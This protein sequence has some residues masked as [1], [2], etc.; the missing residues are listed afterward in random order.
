MS[1]GGIDEYLSG[2][3]V[4]VESIQYLG[5]IPLHPEPPGSSLQM[6]SKL[7]EQVNMLSLT[8]LSS[9]TIVT[10]AVVSVVWEKTDIRLGLR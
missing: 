1:V 3:Q 4:F 7:A 8:V 10:G 5:E 6:I 9:L 2:I